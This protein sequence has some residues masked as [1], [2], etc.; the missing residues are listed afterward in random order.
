MANS[1]TICVNPNTGSSIKIDPDVYELF[2]TAIVDCLKDGRSLTYTEL[3]EGVEKYIQ[4]KKI[5]FTGSVGWY[6]VTVK[7]NM[8]SK[9]QLKVYMAKRK[10]LHKLNS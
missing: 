9:E 3:N 5:P 8:Q 4:K 2:K 6:T 1:K 7:N 10:K